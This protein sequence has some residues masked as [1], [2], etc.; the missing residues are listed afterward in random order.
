MA[1]VNLA[2]LVAVATLVAFK[3]R[4]DWRSPST[5][6]TAG[7]ALSVFSGAWSNFAIPFG[8][9]KA[10]LLG[11][12]AAL[13]V[14]VLLGRV[15]M[16]WR[17]HHLVLASISLFLIAS[18]WVAGTIGTSFGM[19]S[20]LDRAGLIPFAAFIAAPA[21]YK[22]AQQ[23]RLLLVA[24]AGVGGYLGLLSFVEITRASSLVWPGFVADPAQGIHYGRAR[25]PFLESA[26]NGL[27]MVMCAAS[28]AFLLVRSKSVAGHAMLIG[29]I[30]TCAFGA[31][32]TLTRAVWIA[33]FVALIAGLLMST[34]SRKF[35]LPSLGVIVFG[36]LASF[37]IVPQL[38]E[39]AQTRSS[40]SFPV[41]D[42]LNTNRAAVDAGFDNPLFGVGYENF[43]LVGDQYMTQA[44][45]YPLTGE[46]LIIHNVFLSNWAELG[47]VGS[48]LWLAA[49]VSC[50]VV[51]CLTRT[52][53]Q[54]RSWQRLLVVVAIAWFVISML[55][56]TTAAMPTLVL[57]TVAG[58]VVAA[59]NGDLEV[60]DSE[61]GEVGAKSV[62]LEARS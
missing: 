32:F 42:R 7:V 19:F 21:M 20:L 15:S 22:T 5:W 61:T 41:W 59:K 52:S 18:A 4:P 9:D 43:R 54:W 1:F 34:K 53:T 47:L 50:I 8:I 11:S 14:Q 56:P 62:E 51:P 44:G 17:D 37:A 36:V 57:W 48:F 55:G 27:T 3:L 10:L 39:Q 33:A 25:G 35:V 60:E 40:D 58:I 45:S 29:V 38:S 2:I 24:L 28:A 12:L 46:G 6:F 30:A 26:M 31:L 49:F 23:R 16:G 13:A